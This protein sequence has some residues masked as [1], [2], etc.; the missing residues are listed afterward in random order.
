MIYVTSFGA[1]I[2][3]DA[4]EINCTSKSKSWDK[5]LS[6]FFLG[7]VDLYMG[8]TSVNFENAWQFAKTYS[9][10]VNSNGNPTQKYWD[11]AKKGWADSWAH[12]YPM[13]R[14][15]IPEYSLWEGEKLGYIE[16]RKKIYIPLYSSTV[17]EIYA[18]RHLEAVALKA[19]EDGKDLYIKDYDGYN[20][21]RIGMTYDDVINCESRKMG[22][23]FC[24]AMLLDKELS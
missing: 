5:A 24:L 4:I 18:F 7:P 15:A 8:L 21:K 14:G 22:H 6:P 17:K 12:R 10:H 3:D 23:G 2:P 1:K 13:G 16:A 11:W 20:H 19:K 9:Q